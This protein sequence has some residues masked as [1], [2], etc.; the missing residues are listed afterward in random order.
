MPDQPAA[1]RVKTID[2][3][4]VFDERG[5]FLTARTTR[6]DAE[7]AAAIYGGTL[8]RSSGFTVDPVQITRFLP[9]AG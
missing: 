5:K 8:W 9:K 3:F 6:A 1:V 7:D 4:G 2:G